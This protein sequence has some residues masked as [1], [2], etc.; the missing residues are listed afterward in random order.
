MLNGSRFVG[1]AVFVLVTLA[2]PRGRC[3]ARHVSLRSKA[4]DSD[5]YRSCEQQVKEQGNGRASRFVDV[6]C[7]PGYLALAAPAAVA[8]SEDSSVIA[9]AVRGILVVDGVPNRAPSIIAGSNTNL[10]EPL[11]LSLDITHSEVAVLNQDGHSLLIFNYSSG[12]NLAPARSFDIAGPTPAKALTIDITHDL[13]WV[14]RENGAIDAY[15]RLADVNGRTPA[16]L[17]TPVRSYP[18][19]GSS[20]QSPIAMT[21]D[22]GHQELYVLDMEGN[23]VLSYTL[24]NPASPLTLVRSIRGLATRISNPL[25]LALDPSNG[26]DKIKIIQRDSSGQTQ[27]LSFARTASGDV[28][29]LSDLV[30]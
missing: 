1:L 11:A 3:D 19:N 25:A 24:P 9:F 28:S 21:W 15:S 26:I 27:S 7:L 6:A 22:S 10:N 8:R 30:P 13:I 17:H 2:A 20:A 18:T 29:P 12:G 23:Q 14:A 16:S 4:F 5:S